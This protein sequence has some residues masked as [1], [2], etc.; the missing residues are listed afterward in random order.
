[1]ES[2]SFHALHFPNFDAVTRFGDF[3]KAGFLE[4]RGMNGLGHV[5]LASC[6]FATLRLCGGGKGKGKGKG[7]GFTR[8]MRRGAMRR[9]MTGS[10]AIALAPRSEFCFYLRNNTL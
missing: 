2:I 8:A 1:M 7:S 6:D 9:V 3:E 4:A 10:R 5:E